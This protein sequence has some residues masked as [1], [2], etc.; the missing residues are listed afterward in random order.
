MLMDFALKENEVYY[1]QVL[2][3]ER[4]CINKKITR[5]MA[6]DLEIFSGDSDK[7]Y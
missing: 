6:D 7:K 2:L 1:P 5:Y 3:R 4:I